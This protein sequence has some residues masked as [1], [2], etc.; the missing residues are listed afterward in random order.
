MERLLAAADAADVVVD[1]I[2]NARVARFAGLVADDVPVP[3]WSLADLDAIAARHGRRAH[4]AWSSRFPEQGR[5]RTTFGHGGTF[6]PTRPEIAGPVTNDP[7]QGALLRILKHRTRAFLRQRLPEYMVPNR[8]LPLPAF[9]LTPNGKTDRNALKAL[10]RQQTSSADHV[11]PQGPAQD[12]LHEV[13]CAVLGVSRV[14]VAENI[15]DAGTTSLLVVRIQQ[16]LRDRHGIDVPLTAFFAHP[17]ISA[18]AQVLQAPRAAAGRA[19][20][21]RTRNA[22]AARR[23]NH[24]RTGEGR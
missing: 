1:G 23:R 12:L 6:V 5:V 4:H 11:A 20:S 8:V 14:S 24:R 7:R 19:A 21:P 16:E 13:W 3:P 18:L 9:P 22:T 2:P 10:A 17:T 15:F